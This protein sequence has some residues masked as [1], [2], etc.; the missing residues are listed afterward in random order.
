MNYSNKNL[1]PILIVSFLFLILLNSCQA[2]KYKKVDAKE[3]P[4]EP[5]KRIKKN[6][7]E[8]RGFKFFGN[9]KNV[10]EFDFASSNPLWRASL[11]TIDFMPL[12]SVDYGGGVIITD[13]YDNN[14]KN[15]ESIKLVIKFLSNDVRADALDINIFKKKCKSVNDCKTSSSETTLNNEIK[16]SILKKA[17]LYQKQ[18]VTRN[19]KEYKVITPGEAG[20]SKTN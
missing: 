8:G 2:F 5:E 16:L 20:R 7:E 19:K 1:N 10:G 15:N 6:I 18:T 9:K 14:Q 17:A 4:P 11:D 12:L 3:F 13:W